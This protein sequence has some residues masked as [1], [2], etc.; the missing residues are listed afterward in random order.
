MNKIS[1]YIFEILLP[2]KSNF[3]D[4]NP[5]LVV[6]LVLKF[7]LYYKIKSSLNYDKNQNVKLTIS[8]CSDKVLT[9]IYCKL[10]QACIF[11]F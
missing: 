3:A 2:H 10:I 9:I 1:N 8:L 4:I 5:N 7:F 11:N 6:K